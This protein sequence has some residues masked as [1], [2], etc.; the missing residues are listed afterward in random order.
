MDPLLLGCITVLSN[1]IWREKSRS[2]GQ[3]GEVILDNFVTCVY[4]VNKQ[5]G[6]GGATEG[7][8]SPGG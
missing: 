1:V 5:M 7:G 6:R 8:A 4:K 2:L 3:T